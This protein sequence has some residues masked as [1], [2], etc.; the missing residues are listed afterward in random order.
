MFLSMPIT[1]HK[2]PIKPIG[3]VP[4]PQIDLTIDDGGKSTLTTT[5]P[6]Q[7]R[8]VLYASGMPMPPGT[9]G[10]RMNSTPNCNL[11]TSLGFTPTNSKPDTSLVYGGD[12]KH[13][14]GTPSLDSSVPIELHPIRHFIVVLDDFNTN[15]INNSLIGIAGTETR[16]HPSNSV[17]FRPRSGNKPC[18]YLP[19]TPRTRTQSQL[20]AANVKLL[21]LSAANT[22]NHEPCPSNVLAL[23][24]VPQQGSMLGEILTLTGTGVNSTAREYF[25]PVDLQKIHVKLLDNAGNYVNLQGR[26]WSMSLVITQLYQY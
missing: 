19:T 12:I 17:P 5:D 26:D 11:G 24:P 3:S 18:R 1:A 7:C 2:F 22:S 16:I 8:L 10:C 25:G 9:T 6:N 14:A 20:Y 15:R 13:P 21:S 4:S 23:C